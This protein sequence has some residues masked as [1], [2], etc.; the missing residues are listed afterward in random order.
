MGKR[1][2]MVMRSPQLSPDRLAVATYAA[3]ITAV[4]CAL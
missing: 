2:M 1:I 3:P 4:G